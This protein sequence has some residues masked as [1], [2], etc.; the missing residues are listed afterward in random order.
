MLLFPRG[1]KNKQTVELCYR[2]VNTQR[3]TQVHYMTRVR[4]KI[5]CNFF[6]LPTREISRA[7]SRQKPRE[8]HCD[9]KTVFW[10]GLV[11]LVRSSI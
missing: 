9:S 2:N 1:K 3:C 6:S 7:I 8:H 11:L 4:V 10:F 5:A